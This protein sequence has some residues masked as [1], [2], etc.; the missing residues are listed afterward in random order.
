MRK[1]LGRVDSGSK[2]GVLDFLRGRAGVSLRAPGRP[3][4]CA[5]LTSWPRMNLVL[6]RLLRP[7]NGVRCVGKRQGEQGGGQRHNHPRAPFHSV[8]SE[9][10]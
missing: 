10:L 1:S 9:A 3:E 5:K 2:A 7:R 4:L 6:E 8:L